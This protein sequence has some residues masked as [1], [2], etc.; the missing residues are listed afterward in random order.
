M[1]SINLKPS[2]PAETP[3]LMA[4]F[5]SQIMSQNTNNI[6]ARCQDVASAVTVSVFPWLHAITSRCLSLTW[7]SHRA[8][9]P[10]TTAMWEADNI[11][12]GLQNIWI[13]RY[14]HFDVC[15]YGVAWV[16]TTC[17]WYLCTVMWSLLLIENLQGTN[18]AVTDSS[19]WRIKEF[20]TNAN[21][22]HTDIWGSY[23]LSHLRLKRIN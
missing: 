12:R 22:L 20:S 10:A 18:L 7:P 6:L 5:D 21:H 17:L 4:E 23:L 3:N 19:Y 16:D 11:W 9:P 13:F 8:P 15:C 1:A 14:L 2:S